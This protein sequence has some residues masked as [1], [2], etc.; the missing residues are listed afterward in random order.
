LPL[1]EEK[2]AYLL[3]NTVAMDPNRWTKDKIAYFKFDQL[4]RPIADANFHYVEVWQ[5]HISRE[6]EVTI[7]N[8]SEKASSLGVSFPIVGLY[9]ALHYDGDER[10]KAMDE[11]KRNFDYSKILGAEIIKIFTGKMG[12]EIITDSEYKRSV[13]F[14]KEIAELAKTYKLTITGETHRKTLFET[15]ESCQNFRKDVDA[16]NFKVCF[17]PWDLT[18]TQKAINDYNTLAEQVI[19]VHFQGRKDKKFDLL[20]AAELDY[21][22]LIQAL[23]DK[24]FDEYISIE[25]V[26]N[27]KVIN[28]EDINIPLIMKNGQIDR[29]FILKT[30]EKY[31]MKIFV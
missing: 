7:K 17:Q 5:Y 11:I 28:P 20:E 24:K 4:L 21:D 15:M 3:F 12:P 14:M 10:I 13:D 18:N 25:F 6:H 9:P 23:A 26:K 27:C 31:G 16:E 22:L 2:L 8:L 30:C 19:H 1:K 29:D